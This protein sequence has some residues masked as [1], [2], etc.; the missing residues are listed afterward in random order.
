MPELPEVETTVKDLNK[1]VLGRTFIDAWS[2]FE[3]QVK[4][5]KNFAQFKKEIKGRKIKKVRRKGKNILFDLT[6]NKTLLIH[7]KLTGHLLVGYWTPTHPPPSRESGPL[8]DSGYWRPKFKGPL[9]EKINTYIHLLFT[10]DNSQMLALSDLRKF[11]KVELWNTKELEKSEEVK[12]LGPEPLEKDFTFEK[13]E[14]ILTKK[15]A[16]KGEPRQRRG[17]I[18][19]VLMDQT[20]IAGIG[21]IYSDEI[22]WTAKIHP[23][24]DVSKLNKNELKRVFQAMKKILKKAIRLKGTSISDFRIPSGQKGYYEKE[25]KVYRRESEKCPRC[26]QKIKR[27]KLAG[28]S[29]HFCPACQKL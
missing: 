22:L 4:K 12:N 24:K 1:K 29:A 21:N 16:A 20:V 18:K 17:K 3:K 8:L 6:D 14:E 28:R 19:Q 2:D 26:G 11:A 27:I 5:P 25:R 23:F 13:F 9:E 15:K 7:Q 10:F